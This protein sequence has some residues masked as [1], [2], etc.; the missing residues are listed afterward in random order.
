MTPACI[1]YRGYFLSVD[2]RGR[3]SVRHLGET[4]VF[5]GFDAATQFIDW[6]LETEPYYKQRYK[7]C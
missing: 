6:V 5:M 1:V 2:E 3:Y 7:T 4:Y